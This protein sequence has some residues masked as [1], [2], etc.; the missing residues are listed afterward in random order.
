MKT[1]EKRDTKVTGDV[2]LREVWEAKDNLSSSYGHD[3]DK[4]FAETRKHEEQSGHPFAELQI[5][6]LKT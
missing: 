4:L 1:I 5:K 2:V 6:R 3:L